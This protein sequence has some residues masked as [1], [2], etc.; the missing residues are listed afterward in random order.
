MA[1]AQGV[2]PVRSIFQPVLKHLGHSTGSGVIMP[3][4]DGIRAIAVT[5][6]V[7]FHVYAFGS[8]SPAAFLGPID[9]RPWL[10]TGFIGVDLFF[11]LSG[12]LLM[13]PWTRNYYAGKPPPGKKTFYR[14]RILRIVPAYYAHL[15]FF[16]LV[17]VPAVYSPSMV[18]SPLG[19]MSVLAHLSFTQ[20]LF[21]QTSAGFG[22]NGA[23]W[24]LTIEAIFYL[25]LPFVARHFLGKRAFAG[26]AITLMAAGSWN[27]LSFHQLYDFAIW[28][29]AKVSVYPY[30]ALTIQR[31]LALQFPGQAFY[32]AVGMAMTNLLFLHPFGTQSTSSIR[33]A[34]VTAASVAGLLWIM[35]LLSRINLWQTGWLYVWPVLA[36]L[37]LGVLVLFAATPNV[38][39][40]TILGAAPVRIIGLVSYSIYLWHLP[41][42]F[43]VRELFLPRHLDG[44]QAFH[45]MLATCT[46]LTLLISYFSYVYIE[47]PFLRKR[48]A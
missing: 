18:L 30:D 11:V 3:G 36:A 33:Q 43:F 12:F 24:T 48:D 28:L 44:I 1:T 10:G 22:I 38:V 8:R 23:L 21:P 20:Y 40:N 19:L 32:F 14:R 17:M 4:I 37:V 15:L 31:F 16:F 39:S 25:L 45:F 27:Y 7:V 47:L 9:L 5:L 34:V 29:L 13:Y 6:V 42:I 35:W 26:L 2:T 41:V 46:T